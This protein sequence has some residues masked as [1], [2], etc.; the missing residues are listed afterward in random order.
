MIR[1][2]IGENDFTKHGVTAMYP[3]EGTSSGGDSSEVP[4][5]SEEERKLTWMRDTRTRL[6]MQMELMACKDKSD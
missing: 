1:E 3:K 6:F 2:K 5:C 4:T